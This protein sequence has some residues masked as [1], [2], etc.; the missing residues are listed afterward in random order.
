MNNN[1]IYLKIP[2]TCPICGYPTEIRISE[3]NTKRLYCSN[4][5]CEGKSLNKIDHFVSKKGLDITGLSKMTLEKLIKYGWVE[6]VT[7]LFKLKNHKNEWINK[8][9][10]GI[11]SVT[12]VLNAIDAGAK[13]TTDKYICAIGI[14]NIGKTASKSLANKFGDY[15]T[16]RDAINN[17][18]EELYRIDGIGEVMIGDLLHFDYTEFDE[19]FDKYITEIK[20]VENEKGFSAPLKDLTFVVTGK[21]HIYKN[22][23]EL[24]NCIEENGGKVV[25]AISGKTNYLINND[26]NSTTSKNI[27]AKEMNIPIITEEDLQNLINQKLELYEKF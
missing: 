21:L 23:D 13:C 4:P 2:K 7:D 10:F 8:P 27:K 5:N 16:F 3:G 6:T 18:D 20:P 15:K 12:K 22:R 25:S 9:G 1:I 11:A 14:P 24:K 19:I 17:K 26:I